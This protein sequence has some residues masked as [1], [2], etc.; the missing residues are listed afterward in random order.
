MA[1]LSSEDFNV[2]LEELNSHSLTGSQCNQLSDTVRH[3]RGRIASLL[4]CTL[5][6]GDRVRWTDRYG[7]PSVGTL[8]RVLRKNGQVTKDADGR[9]WRVPLTILERV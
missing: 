8:Q 9:T 6:T 3:Q 5:V 4:R 2:L 7:I 1:K